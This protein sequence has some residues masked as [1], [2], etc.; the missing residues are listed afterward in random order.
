MK[1]ENT[2]LRIKTHLN[3]NSFYET[4][5]QKTSSTFHFA[6]NFLTPKSFT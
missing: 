1:N 2:K 6:G 5:K 4:S 3:K